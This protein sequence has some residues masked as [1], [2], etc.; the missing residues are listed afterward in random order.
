M[1]K[2]AIISIVIIG[3][4]VIIFGAYI[5][6]KKE[7]GTITIPQNESGEQVVNV[8]EVV[9]FLTTADGFTIRY[10]AQDVPGARVMVVDPKGRILVSSTDA[11]TI[12]AL[13]DFNSDGV[14]EKST[15]VLKDLNDPHGMAFKCDSDTSCLLY[16]AEHD[17]LSS[18]IYN[19]ET[20]SAVSRNELLTLDAAKTDR[21]YTRTLQFLG[22]PHENI[23]LISIGSSCNVCNET[24]QRAKIIAYDTVSGTVSDYAVGLR[25]AVF[26]ALNPLSGNIFVTEMGRD[27]LGDTTPPDEIN[28]INPDTWK[29]ENRPNFGWPNCYGKNI[30]D[31]D[32]D[33][34]TYIRNPCMAPFEIPSWFDL[35]SHVAPLGLSFIPEEGWPEEHWF[36]LL[37]AYHGSW[38][39]T[40]PVGYKIVRLL[41]NNKGEV[42][43]SEDFITGWLSADGKKL[44][45]PVDIMAMPGGII[46]ITDDAAGVVYRVARTH[47]E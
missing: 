1:N 33:K 38:N 42:T 27:G 10:F 30:H 34:K 22:S 31:T 3:L 35:P 40:N 14:A 15:T 32:F 44:G 43:G 11:D 19:A 8:G 41:T 36:D 18:Y 45:R 13:E 25:N 29:P 39:S 16:V 4:A 24:G 47:S 9:P 20:A 37:V 26:M 17:Q 46:Y 21:H 5:F 28:V 12:V 6:Y 23:L 7:I 2:R